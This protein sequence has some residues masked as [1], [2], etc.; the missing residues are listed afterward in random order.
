[1]PNKY[2]GLS[3]RIDAKLKT[4]LEK[5]AADD[6]RNVSQ[7]VTVVIERALQEGGYLPATRKSTQR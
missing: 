4:A 5:A 2:P 6:R 7:W 1:M 3:F